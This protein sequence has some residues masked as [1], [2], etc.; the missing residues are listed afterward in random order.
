MELKYFLKSQANEV[1]ES[2][3]TAGL[4]PSAF[5]WRD[6]TGHQSGQTVSQLVHKASGYYF[7]F[8]NVT[9]FYSKWSP[10]AEKLIES[11]GSSAWGS[12]LTLVRKWLAYLKRETESPDLWG[13]ISGEAKILESAASADTSN[14]PFSAEEKA[15]MLNGLNEIK[16]YLLTAHRLDPELVESRLNYLIESSERLGRKDWLNLL[17]SVLVSIVINAA[18]PPEATRELFRFVGTALRQIIHTPLLLT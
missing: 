16:Q 17:V 13:A 4:E 6:I 5:E 1:F 15:Y 10:G 11:E 8:D 2:I 14:V 7:T 18:L 9:A 12:Q 3:T